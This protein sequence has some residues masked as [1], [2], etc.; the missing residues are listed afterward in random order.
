[1]AARARI[2]TAS[3]DFEK[4]TKLVALPTGM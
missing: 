4:A 2:D 3:L 1:M